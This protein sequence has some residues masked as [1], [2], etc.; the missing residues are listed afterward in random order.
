M[1]YVCHWLQ[2]SVCCYCKLLNQ[3]DV[4]YKLAISDIA[5][6]L[7]ESQRTILKQELQERASDPVIFKRRF[8]ML[9]QL[10]EYESQIYKKIYNFNTD[11]FQ[12]YNLAIHL[13]VQ[14]IQ[15]VT[16]RSG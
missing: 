10:A 14:E 16:N 7:I 5:S 3:I 2:S 15:D 9:T 8:R 4:F 6:K 11:D 13:I 1:D 12:D